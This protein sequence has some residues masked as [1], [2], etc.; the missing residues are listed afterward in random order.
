[1]V[2][3]GRLRCSHG[4]RSQEDA[5]FQEVIDRLSKHLMSTSRVNIGCQPRESA[6][7]NCPTV[8][9]ELIS[10]LLKVL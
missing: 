6:E 5:S 2:S 9:I 8:Q 3:R 1:M 10:F 7:T 4:S